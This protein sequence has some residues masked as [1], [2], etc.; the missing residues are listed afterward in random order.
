M[1]SYDKENILFCH[2]LEK[3]LIDTQSKVKTTFNLTLGSTK[4]QFYP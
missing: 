3:K 1:I 4:N 2:V